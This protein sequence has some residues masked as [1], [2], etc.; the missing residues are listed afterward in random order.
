MIDTDI[1]G[2]YQFAPDYKISKYA[3][4]E[5]IKIIWN[6]HDITLVPNDSL[7]QDKTLINSKQEIPNYLMPLSYF[8]MLKEY[9]E[10]LR[11]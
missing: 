10:W 9:K 11:I 3:L 8:D 1:V 2:L 7:K 4:L 5:L 6:R